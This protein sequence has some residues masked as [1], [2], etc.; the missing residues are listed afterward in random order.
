MSKKFLQIAAVVVAVGLT[1]FGGPLGSIALLGA[2][3]GVGALLSVGV[4]L[5]AGILLKPKAP[6]V[7]PSHIDR[8]IATLDPN[9]ARKFVP[10]HTAMAT[11][12]RYE[13]YT[14]TDQ[15]YV[16]WIMTVASHEVKSI[17][18]IWFDTE[19]AWSQS[20]GVTS[21]WTGYLTVTPRLVGTSGNGIA[22]D[23]VWT[24]ACTLTGCAYL[25]LQFKRTGSTSKATS[26][27]SASIPSRITV[28]GKGAKLPDIR[29]GGCSATDQTTWDWFSDD[30]GRNPALQLLFYLIGWQI[31]GKLAVGR[32]IPASRIDLNSFI[33]AANLCDETVTLAAGGT[34]PRY[35]SD[36]IFS[37]GDDPSLVIGNLCATMNA[38]LRDTGG[39]ISVYC[40]HNDLSTPIA[41]FSEADI[42]EDGEWEQTPPLDQFF[43]IV[44]GR[45]TNPSDAS[46]YQL[47]DYPE[48]SIASVDA[49]QR[50]DSFDLPLVH[51]PSQAE[52]LAKQR[53]ERSLYRGLYSVKVNERGWQVNLGDVVTWSHATLG[54]TNK[55]FRVAGHSVGLSGIVSLVLQE[56]NAAIYAWDREESPAVVAA[57]PTVYNYLNDPLVAGIGVAGTT[58]DWPSVTD[59]LSTK[60]ANNATVGAGW[61]T[62]LS[63]RPANV[64]ALTGSEGIQNTLVSLSSGGAISGAGG[65]ALTLTGVQ[66]A[67]GKTLDNSAITVSAGILA[68]IGTGSGAEVDNSYLGLATDTGGTGGR[69]RVI[70]S[71][72][73][74]STVLNTLQL[75]AAAQNLDIT[76]TGNNITGIGTGNNTPVANAGVSLT[77]GGALSGAGGGALTISGVETAFG[78][79]LR[80]DAIT[81][82]AGVLS[83][84]GTPSVEVDNS[85]LTLTSDSA[86]TGGRARVLLNT[87]AG[88]TTLTTLQLP[89]AS[90]N[91]DITISGNNL[92]GIGTGSGTAVVNAGV[93]L[94]AGGALAGAGGG[95]LTISGLETAFSET[96]RNSAITVS[97]GLLNG[98]GTG[99]NT[100]V[101]NSLINV[102]SGLI[103]GIGTG[104]GS[105]VGNSLITISGTAITGIGTGSGTNVVNSGVSIGA[106]GTLVG[107]GGGQVTAP[108]LGVA[109]GATADI[110]LTPVRGSSYATVVGNSI[111]QGSLG[112]NFDTACY[113][114]PI[115]GA[116]FAE[117]NVIAGANFTMVA[118]DDENT[119][120]DYLTQVATVFY[121]AS[122]GNF[123]VYFNGTPQTVPTVASGLTGKLQIVCDRVNVYV[124][125]GGVVRAGPYTAPAALT[126]AAAIYPKFYAYTA[127]STQT[128]NRAGPWTD[129][130]AS[131]TIYTGGA[132]VESLKPSEASADVTATVAGSAAFIINCDSSGAP[133]TGELSKLQQ[134]KLYVGGVAQTSGVT[135]SATT[136]SGVTTSLTGTGQLDLGVT[137]LSVDSIEVV[138][139][140]ARSG[141]NSAYFNVTISKS[142][143]PPAAGSTPG[144][145]GGT[146]ASQ[147]SGFTAT[148]SGTAAAIT[149]DLAVTVGTGGVVTLAA[150]I[151]SKANRAS[152][153]G[154]WYLRYQWYRWNGSAWVSI[155]STFDASDTAVTQDA[156][157][158]AYFNTP[159][160]SVSSS[161]TYTSSNGAS[162]KFR[163]YAF[164]ISGTS[165]N[166]TKVINYTGTASAQG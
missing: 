30:S 93:S 121:R 33:T 66:T 92:N 157:T 87:N 90:Q 37:E 119:T 117:A 4:G 162:E 55:L 54:W 152:P 24:S 8:L 46:L 53:L 140:A 164:I 42:I 147:T 112:A 41:H 135:W 63:G 56:E 3:I 86:G 143:A 11:D 62:N 76:V 65:G 100:A 103:G 122:D 29:V 32:G 74:G 120:Y 148:S 15:E 67:F 27:F 131:S 142:Y 36:G 97:S 141:K 38:V 106:D 1:V 149:G 25:H 7:S 153:I 69:A 59:S 156:E 101:G 68:G 83:G 16:H 57:A 133:L 85:R 94:S 45:Y 31:N 99:N 115:Y 80:N 110:V 49:I 159:G 20:G 64:A 139:T 127:G 48:V 125:I 151:T 34:E 40:L 35:R 17:D 108:G 109:S 136:P 9:A 132:T 51:S 158:S 73:A 150:S 89:A 47:V 98:I 163:L 18:E 146:L 44:R 12:V 52:R 5:A 23:G 138:L 78:K 77:S 13:G 123:Q 129:N 14:G 118:L 71:R 61:G 58:A 105:A 43:N 6:R 50:I 60:P 21:K 124:I 81:V 88:A 134:Y 91:F 10:G 130:L 28:R 95:S 145:T 22:I 113:A 104:S 128:G 116:S 111:G 166:T 160:G 154:D 102:T 96:L 137:A 155:G 165:T 114:L 107:G 75:P 79:V 82:S 2:H 161:T 26:P 144:T 19:M 70:L 72:N 126:G 84:I 39:K